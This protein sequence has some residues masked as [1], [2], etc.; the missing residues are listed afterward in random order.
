MET[1]WKRY[2]NAY[3]AQKAQKA[4]AR[5]RRCSLNHVVLMD[6]IY[7]PV[8]IIYSDL[9]EVYVFHALLIFLEGVNVLPTF[10]D[11]RNDPKLFAGRRG[12]FLREVPLK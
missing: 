1:L 9:M 8:P 4:N 7:L 11:L 10:I 3:T 2:G 12:F 6:M 5:E